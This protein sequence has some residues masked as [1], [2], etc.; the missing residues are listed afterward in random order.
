LNSRSVDPCGC[1]DAG[2]SLNKSTTFTKRS[3]R[4]GAFSRRMVL[5]SCGDV[6]TMTTSVSSPASVLAR[7]QIPR[8]LVQCI[9]RTYPA[10][11]A[12]AVLH[13]KSEDRNRCDLQK[14]PSF[15]SA[16]IELFTT[17]SRRPK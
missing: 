16:G 7:A 8:P 10:A 9:R 14:T 11:P 4:S 13:E 15:R 1:S 6:A 12:A 3:F 5:A 2:C 17:K